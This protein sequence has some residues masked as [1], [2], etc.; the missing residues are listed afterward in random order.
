MESLLAVV[1]FKPDDL[2]CG[3]K[4]SGLLNI[5]MSNFRRQRIPYR[6]SSTG[7]RAMSECFGFLPVDCVSVSLYQ[8]HFTQKS[9]L[10]PV[11]CV[12]VSVY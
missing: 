12:S 9:T 7:K 3:L 10:Q 6:R 2:Q 11:D 1:G 4:C 5:G 8:L